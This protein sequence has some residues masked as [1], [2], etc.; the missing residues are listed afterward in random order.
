[1][2][3][4]VS[5]AVQKTKQLQAK[6]DD[7]TAEAAA[8]AALQQ[9]LAAAAQREKASQASASKCRCSMLVLEKVGGHKAGS[10]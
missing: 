7:L 8:A 9:Q 3:K 4:R 10:S 1:M 6:M 2:C 5:Q